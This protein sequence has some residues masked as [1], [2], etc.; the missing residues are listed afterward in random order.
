MGEGR[1]GVTGP[2]SRNLVSSWRD[3]LA[4]LRETAI[5]LLILAFVLFPR[6]LG[7]R[8]QAIGV[9]NIEFAGVKIDVA[10]VVKAK[11]A[12]QGIAGQ[13]KRDSVAVDTLIGRLRSIQQAAPPEVRTQLQAVTSGLELTQRN[14]AAADSSLRRSIAVQ[15]SVLAKVAPGQVAQE[16]WIFAGRVNQARTAWDA[17]SARALAATPANVVPGRRLTTAGDVYLRNASQPLE[18]AQAP[19]LGVL[20]RGDTVQIVARDSSSA[21]TGG[22]FLWAKVRRP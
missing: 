16:G 5:V 4:A 10:S 19:V 12:A 15:D 17:R 18:H 6:A 13:L 7:G 8:L 1:G 22:W 9:G 11:A 14:A 21:R 2:G 20:G 3:A